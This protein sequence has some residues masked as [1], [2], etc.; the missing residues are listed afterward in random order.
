MGTY[1]VPIASVHLSMRAV[2]YH[3]LVNGQVAQEYE[4]TGKQVKKHSSCTN[5]SS[6][7]RRVQAQQENSTNIYILTE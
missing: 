7:S 6:T 3:C 5:G 4:P 2:Y 1:D